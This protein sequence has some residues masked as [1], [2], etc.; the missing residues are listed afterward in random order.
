MKEVVRPNEAEAETHAARVREVFP[1]EVVIN[2]ATI[3]VAGW[4]QDNY[5]EFW[6]EV[7]RR[8][9]IRVI[10]SPGWAFSRGAR[11]EIDLAL[12]LEKPVLDVRG[13]SLSP[14]QLDEADQAAY[15]ELIG[16]GFDEEE[17]SAILPPL[18]SAESQWHLGLVENQAKSDS[19]SSQDSWAANE[20]FAW[21]RSERFYQI[22]KFGIAQ[23]DTHTRQGIDYDGWWWR[24][25]T[26]YYHRALILGINSPQGRQALAKFIATGCGL[27][28]SVV[29]VHGALP[30]PG[31]PSGENIPADR[32]QS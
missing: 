4:S 14:E 18:G 5:G 32:D 31:V 23:D 25:L 26:N 1:H 15:E 29:R 8:F 2:P 27:L 11:R 3:H 19:Y 7:V 22:A 16:Q 21:L 17:I 10:A 13:Q 28:E 24:Q 9:A 6:D 12:R 30:A 20:I